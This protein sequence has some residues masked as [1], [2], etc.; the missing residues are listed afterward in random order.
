V[1]SSDPSDTAAA[2][3]DMVKSAR[4]DTMAAREALRANPDPSKTE[5]RVL[6]GT[7]PPGN[8]DPK[9]DLQVA[10][11]ILEDQTLLANALQPIAAPELAKR[12]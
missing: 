4:L 6:H 11:R 9:L 3:L 5:I 7:C 12:P 10:T 2:V 1:A 8:S